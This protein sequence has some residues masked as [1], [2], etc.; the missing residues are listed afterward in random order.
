MDMIKRLWGFAGVAL[1]GAFVAA[2]NNG[3]SSSTTSPTPPSTTTTLS[4]TVQP[5]VGN[6]DFQQFT[7]AAAGEI[8]VSLTAAGPPPTIQV[9]LGLGSMS[10]DGTTCLLSTTFQTVV[11]ASATPVWSVSAPA[12]VY[13]VEVVDIGN[14]AVPISYTVI[15]AHS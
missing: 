15:V 11:S 3:G 1:V 8:D 7:T 14:A 9:G 4:G 10:S 13:C 2:C 6:Y 5:G 12:G